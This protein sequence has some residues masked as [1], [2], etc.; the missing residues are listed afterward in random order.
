M[1]DARLRCILRFRVLR[2]AVQRN[3]ITCS[4]RVHSTLFFITRECIVW[5]PLFFQCFFRKKKNVYYKRRASHHRYYYYYYYCRRHCSWL[6]KRSSNA[7]LFLALLNSILR[8]F[9]FFFTLDRFS[10]RPRTR[11]RRSGRCSAPKVVLFFERSQCF[12]DVTRLYGFG[13][14]YNTSRRF[15]IFVITISSVV[16]VAQYYRRYLVFYTLRDVEKILKCRFA[17]YAAGE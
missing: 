7:F 8:K 1:H 11:P 10:R 17:N 4:L 15:I 5:R 9:C 13:I 16:S 12:A 2:F 6:S 14:D 3:N